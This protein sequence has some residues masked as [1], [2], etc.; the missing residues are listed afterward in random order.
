MVLSIS[1]VKGIWIVKFMALP[2]TGPPRR[3]Q[4]EKR[5]NFLSTST[6]ML[7]KKP[8]CIVMMP[9]NKSTKTLKFMAPGSI[10]ENQGWGQYSHIIKKNFYSYI[11]MYMYQM[12]FR[13]SVE[14]NTLHIKI[15]QCFLCK[16]IFFCSFLHFILYPIFLNY[17]FLTIFFKL[18]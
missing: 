11:Y 10:V 5:P 18:K 14:I 2:S 9:I 8:K 3:G 4:Y 6:H 15:K 17:C 1:I 16:T 13:A 12:I 7:G